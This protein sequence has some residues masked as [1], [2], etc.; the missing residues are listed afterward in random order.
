MALLEFC[1]AHAVESWAHSIPLPTARVILL[2]NTFSL[3]CSKPKKEGRRNKTG[4]KEE[5]ESK[6]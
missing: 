6:N 5:R 4:S 3:N 2:S 1:L